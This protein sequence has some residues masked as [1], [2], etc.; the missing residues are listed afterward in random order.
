MSLI[1]TTL[2]II[3]LLCQQTDN[4][5]VQILDKEFGKPVPYATIK[6]L[7]GSFGIATSKNGNAAIIADS[8][9]LGKQFVISSV[10]YFTDTIRILPLLKS[11]TAIIHLTSK[12]YEI[13]EFVVK[14]NRKQEEL[15]VGI[16]K[17]ATIGWAS[18]HGNVSQ[19][20]LYFPNENHVGLIEEVSYFIR[21]N[22]FPEAPFRVRIYSSHTD[23]VFPDNDI[24]PISL[25]VSANKKGWFSVD[26]RE[27]QIPIP[28]NGFFVALEWIMDSDD[29]FYN[30]GLSYGATLGLTKKHPYHHS[31][32]YRLWNKI[33]WYNSP[34]LPPELSTILNPMIRA[35][36]L[37][38]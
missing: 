17:S 5:N 33:G 11:N 35:K 25:I 37:L 7:D 10:G 16:K 24:L 8:L 18:K 9:L 32:D 31:W 36:L 23:S 22:G 12:P 27:F 28:K 4:I 13:P 21:G 15:M 19:T 2:L 38:D 3:N 14:G 34:P 6:A 20:A 26:L 29:Y 30:E 1:S